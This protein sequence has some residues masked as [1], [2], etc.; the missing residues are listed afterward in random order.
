[1]P[2]SSWVLIEQA[3]SVL[4]ER[5][6]LDDQAALTRLRRQARCSAR[7]LADVVREIIGDHPR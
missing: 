7:K 1:M 6:D 4:I 3:K 5:Y 2:C